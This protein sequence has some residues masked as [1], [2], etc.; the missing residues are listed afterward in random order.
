MLAEDQERAP[1]GMLFR[2]EGFPG[3]PT[4]PNRIASDSST[5]EGFGGS[6]QPCLSMAQPPTSASW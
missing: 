5:F 3:P 6:A 4:E 1:F 2:R